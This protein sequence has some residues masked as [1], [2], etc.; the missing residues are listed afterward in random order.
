VAILGVDNDE[1][2]CNSSNPPIS[3][4]ALATGAAGFEAAALLARMMTER[5]VEP[6]GIVVKPTQV[7]SRQST[8]I[9]AIDDAAMVRALRH[10]RDHSGR[11]VG[12]R[13]V[14]AVAGV[15]RR[16]LQDRF[17]QYL[18]RTPMQEIHRCRAERIAR[19]LIDTNMTVSEIAAATGFEIDAHFA[20]FFSR[21]FGVTPMAYRNQNRAY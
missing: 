5:H 7:V 8:D 1:H 15:S 11:A 20:R 2:V 6:T 19:L 3:S 17:K 14:S 16:I 10:I 18:R 9:L 12:V 21:Q 4:I 13:E